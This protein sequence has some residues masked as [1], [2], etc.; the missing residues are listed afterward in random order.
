MRQ[1]LHSQ[2]FFLFLAIEMFMVHGMKDKIQYTPTI[3]VLLFANM[4]VTP[5]TALLKL[6][7]K[8]D[9]LRNFFSGHSGMPPKE[10]IVTRYLH[11]SKNH[12]YQLFT[13]QR[14]ISID[15]S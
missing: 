6:G 7:F 10:N 9:F 11:C 8:T 2:F 5:G 14:I 12:Q 15:C 4:E 13:V 1:L 3:Q